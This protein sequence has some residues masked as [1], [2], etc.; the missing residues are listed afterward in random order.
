MMLD[1]E[2][3]GSTGPGGGE[4][5]TDEPGETEEAPEP[6]FDEILDCCGRPFSQVIA[7]LEEKIESLSQFK[8]LKVS[9]DDLDTEAS[10]PE[11]CK[12]SNLHHTE[13][14]KKVADSTGATTL[15]HYITKL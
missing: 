6:L 11:W 8:V 2:G 12:N 3:G 1:P 13:L 5:E 10:I 4:P 7:L 15:Y 14:L 9:S